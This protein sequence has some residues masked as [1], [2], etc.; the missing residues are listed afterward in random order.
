M[1]TSRVLVDGTFDLFSLKHINILEKLKQSGHTVL[2]GVYS[3]DELKKHNLVT[4]MT[5]YERIETLKHSR[6]VDEII[7][8]SPFIVNSQFLKENN[9]ALVFGDKLDQRYELVSE[10]FRLLEDCVGA[11]ADE[12]IARVLNQLDEY[13]ERNFSRGYSYEDMNFDKK[14]AICMMLRLA[15]KKIN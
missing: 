1:D 8:P 2:V 12:I 4:V 13:C 6:L 5:E 15:N 9:I 3:D 11:D 10:Q 14:E 7:F